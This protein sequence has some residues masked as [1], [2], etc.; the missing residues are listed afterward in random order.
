MT[1][2]MPQDSRVTAGQ[3]L[4]IGFFVATCFSIIVLLGR[5]LLGPAAFQQVGLNWITIIAV[6]YVTLPI[7]GFAYGTLSPC[8]LNPFGAIA[9]GVLFMLPAYVL[10]T[11]LIGFATGKVPSIKT[12]VLLGLSLAVFGGSIM[13]LWTWIDDTKGRRPDIRERT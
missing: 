8:R 10:F 13:G 6:Y 5:L 7:G 11:T 1:A 3:G 9:R 2:K 4:K 12:G